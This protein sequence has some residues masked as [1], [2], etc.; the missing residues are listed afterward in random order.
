MYPLKDFF[1]QL[2]LSR[3]Q[4]GDAVILSETTAGNYIPVYS[5]NRVYL[6]HDNTVRFE[7]KK[8]EVKQFF[9]GI[10]SVSAA[11]VWLNEKEISRVYYGPQEQEDLPAGRQGAGVKD[12]RDKYPFLINRYTNPHVT[13]Y[14]IE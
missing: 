2:F 13:V 3:I 5:G 6:G 11:K 9:S 4:L 12:L 14:S 10:M 7:S 1:L 8:E